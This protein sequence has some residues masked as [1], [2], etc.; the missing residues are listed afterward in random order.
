MNYCI[1]VFCFELDVVNGVVSVSMDL[2]MVGIIVMLLCLLQE[3][4]G[5]WQGKLKMNNDFNVVSFIGSY[6]VDCGLCVW[7]VYL[8]CMNN[9]QY[10]G[11]SFV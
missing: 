11:V 1:Q 7:Y 5:D 6:S 8:Y 2:L 4:C 3:F 9:V 10:V